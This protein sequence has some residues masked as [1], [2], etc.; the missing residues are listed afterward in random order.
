M[1]KKLLL[2]YLFCLCTLAAWAQNG[3]LSGT[4]R[5][6]KGEP[7]PFTTISTPVGASTKGVQTDFDGLYTIELPAGSY[8]I[9]FSYVGLQ[10]QT[11]SQTISAGGTHTLDVA[12]KANNAVLDVVVVTGSKFE[13]RASEEVNS[14]AVIKADLVSN[15]NATSIERSLE[16]VPGVDIIDGQANIRGGSGYSYGAG[17]RVMLLMDD[18]PVLNADSGYPDWDFL[19]VENLDQVEIIKGASSALY[20]SSALNGII[21]LRTAY[22]K[23]TPQ[24]KVS[25]FGVLYGLPRDNRINDT[26]QKAWWKENGEAPPYE[27]GLSFGHSQKFGHFDLVMGGYFFD[28]KS[29]RATQYSR[30]GRINFNTR[31]RMPNVPGLSFGVNLNTQLQGSGS[32]LIANG[33]NEQI[34]RLWTALDTLKNK[35]FALTVDPFVEYF[36]ASTGLKLKLQG[37]YYKNDNRNNTNQSTLTDYYYGE[38]QAQKR[39]ED[40]NLIVTGGVVTNRAISNAE[41]YSPDPNNPVTHRASNI[42][43]YLQVDKKFFN[44]LNVS[45]GG[46]YERNEIDGDAE[47]KPVFRA[48]LNYEVAKATFLRA[49]FG[50]G[51]RFPTIAEKFVVTSLGNVNLG[52]FGFPVGIYPNSNLKSETGWSAE[53]GIKQGFK[54]SDWMG[55]VDL[56]GFINEY[57]DMMEFTF[58]VADGLGTFPIL[59]QACPGLFP[60]EKS[61]VDLPTGAIA[62]FQSINI[63]NTRIVGS[64]INVAGQGKLFGN[65]T[66]VLVGYTFINPKFKTWD[67]LQNKLSSADVNV[68]KYR[69]RHTVKG[70]L[71]TTLGKFTIGTTLQYYSFMEAIDEAF[72]CFLPGVQ[73]WRST[74]D[75]GDFILDLRAGYQITPSFNVGFLCKNVFNREYALR[76]ALVDAPRN[77]TLRL[78]YNFQ[79]KDKR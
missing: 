4:V 54:I 52:G 27:A 64:E 56:S 9:K 63:G 53:L 3:T 1:M 73:E 59:V 74:H 7:L 31:Y 5:D 35:G 39:F 22:P 40:I 60:L 75:S 44:K 11:I 26:I 16:K 70:D 15:Q 30:R 34:Y 58:G 43:G 24:T 18:M 67:S 32:F 12:L 77:Y 37:R 47:A 65:P 13:K 50:Q 79:G 10:D 23:S 41:L 55:F 49:S 17:S 62:G 28:S 66:T 33:A 42:A 8:Q 78:T 25:L 69:F 36:Q 2:N 6:D 38:L 21:N 72:N 29:W 19:P 76:P 61:P 71:E 57:Q 45:L 68:L 48:G 46:R 14:I 20:G 51:Y